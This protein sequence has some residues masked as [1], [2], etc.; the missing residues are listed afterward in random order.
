MTIPIERTYA[1]IN[2]RAFLLDL[3]DRKKT[4]R[5]P[6]EIREKARRLLKH[7]PMEYYLEKASEKCPDIFGKLKI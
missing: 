7:Y 5:V 2:T 6:I 4:P 3:L 1:I